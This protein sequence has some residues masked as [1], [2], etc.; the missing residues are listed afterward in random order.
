MHTGTPDPR[1]HWYCVRWPDGS[2][3]HVRT[4]SPQA[5][6]EWTRQAGALPLAKR[7]TVT[8]GTC[9]RTGGIL[10]LLPISDLEKGNAA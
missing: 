5:A 9:A 3:L 7:P 2:C 6:R 8:P 10:P 1:K 4:T